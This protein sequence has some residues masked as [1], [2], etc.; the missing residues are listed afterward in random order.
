MKD[1]IYDPSRERW[2]CQF[3]CLKTAMAEALHK[4]WLI[5]NYISVAHKT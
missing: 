1:Y 4:A 5:Q 2:G 3:L